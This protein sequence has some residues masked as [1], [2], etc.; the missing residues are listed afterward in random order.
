MAELQLQEEAQSRFKK[1]AR[2]ASTSASICKL[3]GLV[4]ALASPLALVAGPY[5]LPLTAGLLA[6]GAT[7]AAIGS[8]ATSNKR[9]AQMAELNAWLQMNGQQASN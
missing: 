3:C 5:G 1:A 9:A 7:T 8:S 4:M 2:A 6:D